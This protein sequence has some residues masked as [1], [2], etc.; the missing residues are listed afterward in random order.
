MYTRRFFA[1]QL[2]RAALISIAAMVTFALLASVP[3][4]Q[5]AAEGSPARARPVE[6]A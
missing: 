2:G 1:S 3:P 4:A 6:L 5:A